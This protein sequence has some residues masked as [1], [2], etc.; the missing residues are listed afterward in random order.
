MSVLASLRGET[1][2]DYVDNAIKLAGFAMN[3][4]RKA[5]PKGYTFYGGTKICE[6]AIEVASHA[7]RANGIYPT[8][9]DEARM[10]RKELLLARAALKDLVVWVASMFE[11]IHFEMKILEEWSMYIDK[12][13]AL[14]AGILDSDARRAKSLPD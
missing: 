2:V 14:L 3:T 5:I 12:E 8:N 9:K 7:D 13:F 6:T 1:G 4:C 11:A 10:R